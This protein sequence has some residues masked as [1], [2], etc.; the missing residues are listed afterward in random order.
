[1]IVEDSDLVS[2]EQ[3]DW[4]IQHAGRIQVTLRL[5]RETL[6]PVTELSR[7]KRL[8]DDEGKVQQSL[9]QSTKRV[10]KDNGRGYHT[11]WVSFS[12]TSQ[13]KKRHSDIFKAAT[14]VRC[15][16]V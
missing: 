16:K 4:Q 5:G 7:Q 6:Q 9:I 2:T 8:S 13:Q 15:T 10:T 11:K 3:E 1:M 14:F 12:S